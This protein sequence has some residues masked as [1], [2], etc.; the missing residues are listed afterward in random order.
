MECGSH[1]D[2]S[3][4]LAGTDDHFDSGNK[5]RGEEIVVQHLSIISVSV[6]MNLN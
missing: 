3:V 5:N 6:L 1:V 2:I 4:H